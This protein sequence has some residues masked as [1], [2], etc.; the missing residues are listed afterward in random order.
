MTRLLAE[1]FRHHRWANLSIVAQCAALD[2]ARLEATPAGAYGSIRAT[3]VH[4]ASAEARYVAS[5]TGT[6]P[7]PAIHERAKFP[8]IEAVRGSL[9][10]TGERLLTLAE[11]ETDDRIVT[12]LRGGEPFAI[13]LS[14]FVTQALEHAQEHRRQIAAALAQLGLEP[15]DLS[16]WAFEDWNAAQKA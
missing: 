11:T 16:A 6:P 14:V 13:A 9:T 8:G 10:T 4:L 15:P 5:V 2:E 1:I 3:L 7:D 12:G